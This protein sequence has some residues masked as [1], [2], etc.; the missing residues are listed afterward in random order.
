MNGNAIAI[1]CGFSLAALLLL[2]GS[3]VLRRKQRLLRDLPTS[4]TRG[5]FI[6]LVELK[7]SAECSEPL[8]ALLSEQP[9]VHYETEVSERWSRLVVETTTDSKGRSQTR[10]RTETGWTPVLQKGELADF[11]LRDD[12]GSVLIRPEGAKLE[13]LTL[14]EKTVPRGDPLYYAKAPPLSV[15]NSDHVRRFVERGIPLHTPLYLVGQARERKDLVAPE[16]AAD[17]TA[18]LFLI[19]TRPEEKVSRGYSLG[20]WTLWLLGL[21]AAVGG[22]LVL[23]Q[24]MKLPLSPYWTL[25]A[26]AAFF[27]LWG[28]FWIWVVFNSLIG[29]RERVRRA[30]SLVDVE[31]KRRHD[32]IPSLAAVLGAMKGH[33][34]QVQTLAAE[35][36]TQA[37][38]TPPGQPGPDPAGLTPLLVAVQERYPELKAN[39][40]FARLSRELIETEQRIALART[41]YNDIA[42]HYATRLEVVPDRFVA[43][44]AALRP[45]PLLE[46]QGFERAPV[47]VSFP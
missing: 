24:G 10:T 39:E 6:G 31:L 37:L 41:Y 1:V 16:I 11:Y 32:L 12:T 14:F 47:P 22:P 25:A 29:L 7:G 30:W 2:W 46:T 8:R 23:S 9:C 44:L 42:T 15:P 33:E 18:P 17:K 28:L 20:S 27:L 26:G 21:A 34:A 43:R 45:S 38:A 19:S 40:G 36:R 13:P 4:K 35:L 3:L 5:V